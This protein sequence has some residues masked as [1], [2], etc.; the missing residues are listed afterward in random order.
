MKIA[1]I[2]REFLHIF[3]APLGNSMK[4]S[5]KMRFKIIL[6]VTKSQGSTLSSEDTFFQKTT[7]WR[8][9]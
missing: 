7:R 8:S 1:N 9:I 3:L 5:G 2:D 6:R 4:F